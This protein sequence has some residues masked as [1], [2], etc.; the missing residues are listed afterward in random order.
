[1]FCVFP[2][3]LMSSTYTDKNNPFWRCT[4]RHSQF[5]TFSHTCFNRIFSN[6]LSHNSPAKGW[7]KRFRSRRTTGS[8]ILYHDFGHL[9]FGRRIQMSGHSD[10]GIF[11]NFVSI[12]H[13][14]LGISRYCVCCL[15]IATLQSG[16]DIHDFCCRHLWRWWSLLAKYCIR[17]W[18][19]FHNS[20]RST[21]LPL[22]FWYWGSNSKFLRW[23]MSINDAKWTFLPL[24]LASSIT[25]FKFLTFV[26]CHAWIS[27]VFPFFLHCCLCI[28]YFQS[29]RQR[30]K[31]VHQILVTQLIHTSSCDEVFMVLVLRPS[32]AYP[33]RFVGLNNTSIFRFVLSNCATSFPATHCCWH[34]ISNFL[35]AFS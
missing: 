14:Y 21:T 18:I 6:C 31:F 22:Y 34:R 12:F 20:P 28:W 1:M 13:F 23:Q 32:H 35:R 27:P 19:I 11:N 5:G 15:S 9:C 16:Y 4:K 30:N 2:A 24:F 8:S 17:S 25:Y 10:F 29:F 26:G 33:H 3:N 7:P